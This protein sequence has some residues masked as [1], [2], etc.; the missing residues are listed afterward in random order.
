MT[1]ARVL[2]GLGGVLLLVGLWLALQAN[3]DEVRAIRA[4]EIRDDPW[5]RIRDYAWWPRLIALSHSENRFRLGVG[6][7]V[8]GVAL[9]T[10]GSLLP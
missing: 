1:P 4:V 6:L 9:Q 10:I 8:A 3:R 2:V 7:T 5:G